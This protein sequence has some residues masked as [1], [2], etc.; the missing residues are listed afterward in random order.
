MKKK[1]RRRSANKKSTKTEA[2]QEEVEATAT[3]EA[4]LPEEKY[5]SA[6]AQAPTEAGAEAKAEA[7]SAGEEAPVQEPASVADEGKPEVME[8]APERVPVRG[9]KKP[10]PI[11]FRQWWKE[12]THSG[13]G[14]L[15]GNVQ[16]GLVA[17]AALLFAT[18]L[19]FGLWDC[20]EPHYA[21]TARMMLVRNDWLHPF[22]SYAFFLSKPI[23]MF[24][25]MAASMSV[26]GVSEWAI[27]LPFALHAVLLVWGVYFF[28]SRLFSQRAGL[29][30]A[31]AVGTAPL[32]VFLG[33]QAMADILVGTYIT[34]SL[35]F[36]AL[37][38]FGHRQIREK[39]AQNG[40][41]VP[42]HL[43]YLYFGYA[44]L[45]LSLLAKGMLGP[46]L[47]VAVI[48]G[49]L[50][51]TWDWRILLRIR[52]VSGA[53]LAM[54][55][56][57][58]WYVHMSFFPGRNIDDG[59]TF[60]DRFILHDNFYRLFSGVHGEK[61]VFTYFIQQLGYA[62]GL[63]I[64]F[65]PL[66]LFGVARFETKDPGTEEKLH[67]FLF[68]WWFMIFL[69]FSL[70]QTKFHHY[71]YPLVPISAVLI[72][73]WLDRYLQDNDKPLY[74]YGVLVALGLSF[75][76]LRDV[77][78]NPH[79]LVNMFVYKYS[80]PYPLKDA[81]LLGEQVWRFNLP[82][83]RGLFRPSP[84]TFFSL[85]TAV[86]A[87]FMLSGYLYNARKYLVRGVAGIAIVWAAYHAH[88]FMI[89]LTPHWSQK[90]FFEI[91]KQDSPVWKKKLSPQM[92]LSNALQEPVPKAPLIAFRLNWRGE[93]FYSGNRD[94]QIM[95]TNSFTRLYDAVKRHRRP[96][97][98][99]YFIT[100]IG[101]IKELKRAVGSY[102]KALLRVPELSK[103]RIS[104]KRG[105]RVKWTK[106]PSGLY[107]RWVKATK[108]HVSNFKRFHNKYMLVKLLPKP[109][110]Q[111]RSSWQLKQD[112]KS[113]KQGDEWRRRWWYDKKAKKWRERSWWRARQ[114]LKKKKAAARRAARKAAQRKRRAQLQER[115][116]RLHRKRMRRGF[117]HP[118]FATPPRPATRPTTR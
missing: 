115:M 77:I 87:A 14:L 72:G 1:K 9:P 15:D 97:Q 6:E 104:H 98:P 114:R 70:S 107:F 78:R 52:L 111:V 67:R 41:E 38:V 43:P 71:V 84:E 101:R 12:P 102:D 68:S 56:G 105:R 118:G 22:W 20:W 16:F 24:W 55:I 75:M 116:K 39:A 53:L 109:A 85:F 25:Y 40:Y 110:G 8:P 29:L 42:I 50:L 106:L 79:H 4:E 21:E 27:R 37:A 63:W 113:R 89:K 17:V 19:G 74:H 93:K 5:E 64:G 7:A 32:S 61:G 95:G 83:F 94:L 99:V 58:P 108:R 100:E 10:R 45:G 86:T 2:L 92:K 46:G 103:R 60:L 80:R 112:A 66:G 34:L 36:F 59:K 23:L 69:F 117:R 28:V 11:G 88:V 48:V 96:G 65:V 51:L 44:L 90:T 26:F 81:M 31:L 30:A 33:R 35:G 13:D 54:A 57:L 91:M 82:P 47:P 18:Q 73:I 3:E 76:V 62:M 49:Y